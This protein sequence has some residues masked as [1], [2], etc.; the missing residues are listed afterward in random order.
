M[1]G[2]RPNR[3]LHA[4]QRIEPPGF[5]DHR[6]GSRHVIHPH[7]GW[8]GHRQSQVST[9][10]AQYAPQYVSPYVCQFHRIRSASQY[11]YLDALKFPLRASAT[12]AALALRCPPRGS[13]VSARAARP[14]RSPAGGEWGKPVRRI[15]SAARRSALVD[16]N[17]PARLRY[18]GRAPLGR[19]PRIATPLY[20]RR[21]NR[22]VLDFA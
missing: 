8:G 15:R 10:S 7:S 12:E 14:Y 2:A 17:A 19:L 20:A 3:P 22:R 9:L 16:P 18:C 5:L 13:D 21:Q 6:S 11:T 1:C 4:D